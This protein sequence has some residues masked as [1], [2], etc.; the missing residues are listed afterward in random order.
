M[1]LAGELFLCTSTEELSADQLLQPVQLE[2][3][4]LKPTVLITILARN[5]QHSLSYFLG[6]IDRLDYPKDRIAIW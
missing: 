1:I 5:A 4:L 2:S 6:S 3:S